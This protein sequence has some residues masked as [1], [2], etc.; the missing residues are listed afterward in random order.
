ML[1]GK[2][3]IKMGFEPGPAIGVALKLLPTV[4]KQLGRRVIESDLRAILKEPNAYKEHTHWKMLAEALIE[5]AANLP[6]RR[7]IVN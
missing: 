2:D 4:Q 3:L 6:G 5:H 1:R 7:R